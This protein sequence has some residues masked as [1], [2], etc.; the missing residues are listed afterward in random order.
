MINVFL[1]NK[2]IYKTNDVFN[3]KYNSN[4][5]LGKIISNNDIMKYSYDLAKRLEEYSFNNFKIKYKYDSNNN[6]YQKNYILNDITYD[7]TNE[8]NGDD[9]VTKTTIDNNELNYSYDSLGRLINRNI[10]NNYNTDY[11]YVTNGKRTSLL[12][13]DIKN[14]NNLYSYR[15]DKLNNITHIYY[16]DNLINRYYY[17]EY[18]ELIRENNYLTNE[19]IRYK[20]DNY[21]NI[22]YKKVFE[23]NTY[24]LLE[25]NKYE[26]NNTN[27]VDQ[28]TK[29]NND[30]ITYDG[31]GNPLTIGS[32]T[33]TWINGRQLNSYSDLN[34]N[35]TYKYN[36]DSIRTSKTVNN[37]ETKYYLENSK[38]CRFVKQK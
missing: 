29:F 22:L 16:N 33:L 21:G 13:K 12:I 15:Y 38:V 35:I 25:E 26:Y 9:S 24:N 36:K 28:L 31:I 27:W 6:V 17:D 23:L 32:K 30:I 4:G 8:F 7:I 19:T 18:N 37:V 34:T 14:N 5:D 1:F 2:Y 20:Y 11:S 3:Y 10:N